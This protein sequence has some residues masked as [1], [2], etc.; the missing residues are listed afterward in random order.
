MTRV[1]R[2]QFNLVIDLLKGAGWQ[3]LPVTRSDS[4]HPKGPTLL[5][6]N[7]DRYFNSSN[8]MT[9]DMDLTW[10]GAPG[11]PLQVAF[12]KHQIV[13]GV[14]LH[15]EAGTLTCYADRVGDSDLCRIINSFALLKK[16]GYLAEPCFS[17]TS[18]VGWETI[19]GQQDEQDARAVFWNIQSHEDCFVDDGTLIDDL[20]MQ[21]SGDP[22]VIAE[23]LSSSGLDVTM[24]ESTRGTFYISPLAED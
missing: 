9:D 12:A 20:P 4:P 14:G 19:Y 23:A 22:Q 16:E 1:H 13:A 24:P 7:I 21:W 17:A 8:D 15:V 10:R 18:T 3:I 11:A 2:E 5:I 6:S